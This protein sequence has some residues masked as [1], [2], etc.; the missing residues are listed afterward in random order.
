MRRDDIVQLLAVRPATLVAVGHAH[1]A[2]LLPKSRWRTPHRW[3][4]PRH[5]AT[6]TC[7]SPAPRVDAETIP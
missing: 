4:R 2:F 5:P 1:R 7:A 6:L 3:I